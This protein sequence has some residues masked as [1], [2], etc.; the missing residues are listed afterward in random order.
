MHGVRYGIIAVV[1]ADVMQTYWLGVLQRLQAEVDMIN[2]LS[3]H[4]GVKGGEN[5]STLARM[6]EGLLP[7]RFKVGSGLVIDSA[8]GFSRQIDVLVY[9]AADEPAILAQTNQ[10][11]FPIENVRL[12]IEIK[13]TVDK[14]ATVA[15]S[16]VKESVDALRSKSERSP[17]VALFGYHGGLSAQTTA[18]HLSSG[19]ERP[20]VDFACVLDLGLFGRMSPTA[21]GTAWSGGVTPLQVRDGGGSPIA[22]SHETPLDDEFEHGLRGGRTYPVV[23]LQSGAILAEPSR[24]LLLFCEAVLN[25]L[26]GKPTVLSHYITDAARELIAIE[27]SEAK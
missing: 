23:T 13:T 2:G 6:L 21:G 16:K 5:E 20:P 12:C 18:G 3:S 4:Q 24:A 26:A 22:G 27:V 1:A 25:E 11:L 10:F 14:D 8:G 17:A 9:E 15:A 19:L 7:Q